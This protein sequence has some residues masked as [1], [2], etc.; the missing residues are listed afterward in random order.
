MADLVEQHVNQLRQDKKELTFR[1]KDERAKNEHLRKKLEDADNHL[2]DRSKQLLDGTRQLVANNKEICNTK[3]SISC[4]HIC[5]LLLI[6]STLGEHAHLH[7]RN[8]K[9]C[10]G[11]KCEAGRGTPGI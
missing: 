6:L 5:I 8:G 7:S 3:V 11:C 9:G 1:L 4:L 10:R 2:Q